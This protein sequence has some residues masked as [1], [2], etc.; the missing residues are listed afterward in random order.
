MLAGMV[1]AEL[2]AEAALGVA[3]RSPARQFRRRAER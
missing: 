1:V 2:A 3:R